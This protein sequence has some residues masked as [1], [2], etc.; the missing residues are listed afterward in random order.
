M[1]ASFKSGSGN[2]G[3]RVSLGD[4]YD[5]RRV[6][7]TPLSLHACQ[8]EGVDPYSLTIQG[9]RANR[10]NNGGDDD[11]GLSNNNSSNNSFA[12]RGHS[13]PRKDAVGSMS[14]VRTSAQK[15]KDCADAL[16]D[17][18]IPM[19]KEQQS[20][21]DKFIE[22]RR[23]QLLA[24]VLRT[25]KKLAAP[26]STLPPP[27]MALSGSLPDMSE[28][29]QQKLQQFARKPKS[30]TST[31]RRLADQDGG[32]YRRDDEG[33]EDMM[34]ETARSGGMGSGGLKN[35][36]LLSTDNSQEL[37]RY[38]AKLQE[39]Q[40][41]VWEA[42]LK[43][44]LRDKEEKARRALQ[45]QQ[46]DEEMLR[47]SQQT[48]HKVQTARQRHE[49]HVHERQAHTEQ[50]I[51]R[52]KQR[53]EQ[54]LQRRLQQQEEVR[55]RGMVRGDDQRSRSVKAEADRQQRL[56]EKRQ[57]KESIFMEHSAR[58]E[59]DNTTVLFEKEL[60][61][62]A[63]RDTAMRAQRANEYKKLIFEERVTVANFKEKQRRGEFDER[64]HDAMV[65]RD[66]VHRMK[67]SLD[68]FFAT[69][70]ARPT[71]VTPRY[72]TKGEPGGDLKV[73]PAPLLAKSARQQK[74][75][76]GFGMVDGDSSARRQ[77]KSAAFDNKM[78]SVSKTDLALKSGLLSSRNPA[79]ALPLI[80][81]PTWLAKEVDRLQSN[82]RE[83]S[84]SARRLRQEAN[85]KRVAMPNGSDDGGGGAKPFKR[86]H[87]PRRWPFTAPE[88]VA[89]VAAP[90]WMFQED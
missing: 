84:S 69:L 88:S 60:A 45:I 44:E 6:V 75:S 47:H 50:V 90:K 39:R 21:K 66:A 19:S 81:P 8:L 43:T 46:R 80:A 7:N 55:L 10:N 35:A 25:Y 65:Q 20:I 24:S 14:L 82:Q 53:C 32:N 59:H 41:Q 61:A 11:D 1:F 77:N 17:A 52:D 67:E 38:F 70:P 48:T 58:R 16:F 83:R 56:A 72:N 18:A 28:S 79:D 85:A 62:L 63:A 13:S 76:D 36:T 87:H 4:S 49:E 89:K 30:V 26:R 51:Q 71:E 12:R 5:G 78:L 42:N 86:A 23:Q 22:H 37:A 68:H 33:G 31:L 74:D 54:V 57:E 15:A 40:R 3:P 9:R 29:R 73:L 2:N 34:N 64:F 27:P